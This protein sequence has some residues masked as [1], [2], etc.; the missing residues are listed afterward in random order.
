MANLSLLLQL[1]R[2]AK[3]FLNRRLRIDAMQLPEIDPLDLEMTKAHFDLLRE[4]FGAAHRR[5]L[6]GPWR[7]SPAFVAITRPRLYGASV[8]PM[9]ISL[10]AGP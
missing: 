6:I 3:R 7:V 2:C 5:P 8:S 10:T 4:I 9:R 1:L